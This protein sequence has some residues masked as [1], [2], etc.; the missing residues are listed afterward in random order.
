MRNLSEVLSELFSEAIE[1]VFSEN[2]EVTSAY[3]PA[4]VTQSSHAHYQCNTP[5]RLAKAFK[6]NPREIAASIIEKLD[7]TIFEK[8][9][10]SGPG[11]IN[12]TFAKSFLS[13]QINQVFQDK[14]LGV[15]PLDKRKKIIVE[16]SSP[17]IAKELHVGHLR[18][19]IIGD[20]IARLFEF[21][22]HDVL[23]LNHVGDWGTQFGMLIAYLKKYE[24]EVIQGTKFV[25]LS[26]LMQ[27][28]KNAKKEFDASED[29]KL[30][31]QKEVVKLQSGEEVSLQAWKSICDISRKAFNEIYSI[32]DVDLEERGESTYN[33]ELAPMVAT[34]QEQGF[35]EE[36]DGA[37]C[38]FLEGFKNK[39]GDPLPMIIQK[40]DG[41]FNYDTTD[42]AAL[43]QRAQ[44]EKA[45]RII[46]VT[47][48]GQQLH[49]KMLFAAGLKVGF[50]DP[51]HVQLDHVPFGVVLGP[52][53]K[54]FKTRSGETEKLIDLINNAV[55][56]ARSILEE[57]MP[58]E[59]AES[60]EKFSQILGIDAIKYADL[61]C[62]RIKDYVF[63]YDRMLRFEGNTAAFLLY[64]YVR[65][66]GIKRKAT[67]TL[68]GE[69]RI[70]LEHE[71][72]MALALHIRQFGECLAMFSRDLLPHKLS[73]YLY[74]LAEKFNAF[75]RDCQVVGSEKEASRLL[76]AELTGKILAKGLAI[77]G[78]K[79]LPRM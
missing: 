4:E 76:L 21:L 24:T 70:D 8:L 58:Q 10:V 29:F 65:V 43:K 28:Y 36:S 52:D 59:D 35:I 9:E 78:L 7:D 79:T 15:S 64:S 23:R 44:V 45:D 63:S 57:R 13:D 72:E 26:T 39:E 25:D 18:S 48:L 30:I 47:D 34:L 6:K 12:I 37:K 42:M 61:S 66:Q 67:I 32:L 14:R 55:I 2:L 20:A 3:L 5:L 11:F 19:T 56:K 77:L 71:S 41:G 68:S 50:Y 38:I 33:K 73:E 60:L 75:F 22:G 53:G 49:F 16:F 51:N 46:V 17:N 1:S 54:K 69:E 31:S 74:V 27:W 40:S 62:Q